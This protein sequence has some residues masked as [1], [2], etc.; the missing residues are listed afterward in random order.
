MFFHHP[1]CSRTGKVLLQTQQSLAGHNYLVL[2][3]VE[4]KTLILNPMPQETPTQAAI[5]LKGI[6]KVE[7]LS[8]TQGGVVEM[9]ETWVRIR[10]KK[11]T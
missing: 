2:A 11:F 3:N 7:V 10:K 6:R 1:G 5:E 8:Y 9:D 4:E